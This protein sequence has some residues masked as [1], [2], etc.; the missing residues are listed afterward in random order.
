MSRSYWT[1]GR[2]AGAPVALGLIVIAAS[3]VAVLA[4]G[5]I[6]G[7]EA[8]WKGVEAKRET[9]GQ[10]ELAAGMPAEALPLRRLHRPPIPTAPSIAEGLS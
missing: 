9:A 3:F 8:A 1:T 6:G 10:R 7:L 4:Q 2:I 5:K